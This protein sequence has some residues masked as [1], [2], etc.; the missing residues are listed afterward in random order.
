MVPG[1][2]TFLRSQRGQ[3][4][5]SVANVRTLVR[6]KERCLRV[7]SDPTF[8]WVRLAQ[9]IPVRVRLTDVP[10]GVLIAAGMTYAVVIKE[11]G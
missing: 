6:T 3:T 10:A 8:I 4:L 1:P 5:S 9:C 2:V 7:D 11:N